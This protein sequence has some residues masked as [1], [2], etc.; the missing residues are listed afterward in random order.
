MST[1]RSCNTKVLTYEPEY[2]PCNRDAFIYYNL[3]SS[4]VDVGCQTHLLMPR[5]THFKH[6][7]KY[8][9]SPITNSMIGPTNL[10]KI[11]FNTILKS[12][13]YVQLNLTKLSWKVRFIMTYIL[14]FDH[15]PSLYAISNN[16]KH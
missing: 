7:N 5:T 6:K 10:S 12:E 14:Q 3:T 8:L 2:N 9:G 11:G 16:Y 1:R 4:L 13:F 15:I